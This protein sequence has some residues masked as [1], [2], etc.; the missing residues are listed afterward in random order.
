VAWTE[1]HRQAEA[2]PD[3]ERE[4]FDLV[5]YQGLNYAEAADVLGVSAKT[6]M[7]RWQA[8]CLRLHDAVGGRLPG[9]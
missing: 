7:R 5:Y 3:E 4:A 6:V 2:L 9:L 1:F 8:A